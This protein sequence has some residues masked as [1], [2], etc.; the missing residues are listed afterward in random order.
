MKDEE[1]LEELTPLQRGD[2]VLRIRKRKPRRKLRMAPD[3]PAVFRFIRQVV[4]ETPLVPLIL[5]LAT[6][7]LG[8]LPR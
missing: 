2:K 6:F 3:I 8:Y 1:T 5:A 7:L 4:S